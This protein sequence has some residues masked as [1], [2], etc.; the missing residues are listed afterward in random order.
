MWAAPQ[1]VA[2]N[3]RNGVV[4][5]AAMR[6]AIISLALGTSVAH[7]EVA[8]APHYAAM[9]EKGH[10]WTYEVMSYGEKRSVTCAVAEIVVWHRSIASRI[11]CVGSLGEFVMSQPDRIWLATPDG[12]AR[13]IG[14]DAMTNK[15]DALPM[16]VVMPAKPTVYTEKRRATKSSFFKRTSPAKGT[17]CNVIDDAR[18]E[19]GERTITTTCFHD[20]VGIVSGSIVNLGAKRTDSF[21]LVPPAK[22]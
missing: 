6:S 3:A 8:L 10:T 4:R 21:T 12:L 5:C 2:W 16:E 22:R 9:F 17:W 13:P 20:G 15:Y 14:R 1:S 18:A 7:A 19:F 11:E